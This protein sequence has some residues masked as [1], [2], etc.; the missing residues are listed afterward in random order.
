MRIW[1]LEHIGTNTSPGEAYEVVVSAS[2]Y[3]R[4][5]AVAAAAHGAK[6]ANPERTTCAL[7]NDAD[8]GIISVAFAGGD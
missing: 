8:E 4:A 2:C 5:R 1:Y 3:E 7:A 6:W